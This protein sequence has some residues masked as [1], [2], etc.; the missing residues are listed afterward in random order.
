MSVCS[1]KNELWF[2]PLLYTLVL[3]VR[4]VTHSNPN[5]RVEAVP[6]ELAGQLST[7]KS[8][9]ALSASLPWTPSSFGEKEMLPVGPSQC[10]PERRRSWRRE[11]QG[12]LYRGGSLFSFA[13]APA[14]PAWRCGFAG[15]RGPEGC[16]AGLVPAAC[17]RGGHW[18]Q[19]PS[20]WGGWGKAFSLCWAWC[21]GT[22]EMATG[23]P[24]FSYC[25]DP[26]H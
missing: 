26:D 7:H 9:V 5:A 19:H 25:W 10:K 20:G 15:V 21:K 13:E 11:D 12:M 14:F 16:R 8:L 24:S 3:F 1:P 2:P 23:L 4:N 17:E 18:C 6:A 22:A